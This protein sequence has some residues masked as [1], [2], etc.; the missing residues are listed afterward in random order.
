MIAKWRQ[1]V[2]RIRARI[3]ERNRASV[4]VLDD[5]HHAE[6]TS[7]GEACTEV[8]TKQFAIAEQMQHIYDEQDE[9]ARRA[10]RALYKAMVGPDTETPQRKG[11]H[12]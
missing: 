11:S 1:L 9:L 5:Q 2:A 4:G 12:G 6:M 10:A 8:Q 7:I 3:L